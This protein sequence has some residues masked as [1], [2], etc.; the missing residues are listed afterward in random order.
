[1]Y[2]ALLTHL[3]SCTD[4]GLIAGAVIAAIVISV[5]IV[6][7]LYYVFSVRGYKLSTF[8]LPTKTTSNIDVVS[9]GLDP[10]GLEKKRWFCFYVVSSNAK[11]C[12]SSVAAGFHQPQLHRRIR[13]INHHLSFVQHF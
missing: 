1:M 5:L 12:P 6:G 2:T 13:H 10:Y 11:L 7:L 3:F 4:G 9:Y 8:S